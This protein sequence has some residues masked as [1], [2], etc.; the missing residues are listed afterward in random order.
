MKTLFVSLVAL[1]F[2]FFIGCQSSITDPALSEN[3]AIAEE[4]EMAFKDAV[5]SFPGLIKLD[6]NLF[7]PIHLPYP[8]QMEGTIR[9][10][11]E[12]LTNIDQALKVSIYINATLK[13]G[14]PGQNKHW[15]VYGLTEDVLTSYTNR[16]LEK[17]FE[18]RNTGNCNY[19]FVLRFK[20]NEKEVILISTE[21]KPYV[22]YYANGNVL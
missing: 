17:S 14:C 2:A 16:I 20:V 6:G 21:L 19:K 11:L 5:S 1:L 15:M 18:V 13:S 9:Y 8:V 12:M 7:D 3:T 22:G 10:N 4:E